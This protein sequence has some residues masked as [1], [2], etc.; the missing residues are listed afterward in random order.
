VAAVLTSGQSPTSGLDLA[1]FDATVR[2][3]DDLFRAVNGGWLARTALPPDRVTY[4]TFLELADKTEADL[5]SLSSASAPTPGRQRG[6][7][8]QIADLSGSVMDQARAEEL[9]WSRSPVYLTSI[10][11]LAGR[12]SHHP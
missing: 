12:A 10:F 11:T 1:N 2:P 5:R 6:T 8:L 3:Q 4:G 7:T 9:A